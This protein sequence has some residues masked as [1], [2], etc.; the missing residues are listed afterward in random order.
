MEN[1]SHYLTNMNTDQ[2][3]QRH[4]ISNDMLKEFMNEE[5][6]KPNGIWKQGIEQLDSILH[7]ISQ[8]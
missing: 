8:Q 2:G 5:E 6:L 7:G 4:L 1:G 3:F